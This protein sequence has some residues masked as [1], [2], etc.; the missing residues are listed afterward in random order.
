MGGAG[1]INRQ[2]VA[3]TE[4]KKP[5]YHSNTRLYTTQHWV[6]GSARPGSYFKTESRYPDWDSVLYVSMARPRIENFQFRDLD[7]NWYF[8]CLVW[9]CD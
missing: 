2:D 9:D 4:T 6:Q 5:G 3:L 7:G 1:I 8:L